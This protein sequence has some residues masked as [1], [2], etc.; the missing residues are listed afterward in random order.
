MRFLKVS[1]ILSVL[2]LTTSLT[3]TAGVDVAPWPMYQHDAFQSGSSSFPGPDGLSTELF[4][5]P[6]SAATSSP[7]IVYER[8][9]Y[10]GSSNGRIYEVP[11]DQDSPAVEIYYTGAGNIVSST[12]S[13]TADGILYVGSHAGLNY[14]QNGYLYAID[15]G[16]KS[17]IWKLRLGT[18][19]KSSPIVT[20]TGK[21]FVVASVSATEGALFCVDSSGTIEWQQSLGKVTDPLFPAFDTAS[22]AVDMAGNVYITS[23]DNQD[24][25]RL[26]VFRG[27]S[28]EPVA[29]KVFYDEMVTSSPVIG[30]D[31]ATVYIT[32][33]KIDFASIDISN[34][35]TL[36]F[37]KLRA[38]HVTGSGEFV[39]DWSCSPKFP[40]PPLLTFVVNIAGS[41]LGA[42]DLANNIPSAF[43][44]APAV[45]PDGDL[46]L[47]GAIGALY[48]ID[49]VNGEI[50]WSTPLID[51]N[52]TFLAIAADITGFMDELT[53]DPMA[54]L[55]RYLDPIM[56]SPIT[57]GDT[58][59][60]F[61]IYVRTGNT[62]FAYRNNGQEIGSEYEAED[63][64]PAQADK[65]DRLSG[66]ALGANR[67]VYISSTDGN[68]YGIGALDNSYKISGTITSATLVTDI[69]VSLT[70]S[71]VGSVIIDSGETYEFSNL[72]R[73]NYIVTP[74]K[75][76]VDFSPSSITI[77]AIPN[78]FDLVLGAIQLTADTIQDFTIGDANTP[79]VITAYLDPPFLLPGEPVSI[80]M[81]ITSPGSGTVDSVTFDLSALGGPP[82]QPVVAS[83]S[84]GE[85]GPAG[86]GY[87]I[88]YDVP[89]DTSPGLKEI[90]ITI[91]D[92]N[93]LVVQQVVTLDVI[94]EIHEVVTGTTTQYVTNDF[95]GQTLILTYSSEGGNLFLQVFEPSDD[96]DSPSYL[97]TTPYEFTMSS[98]E[99]VCFIYNAAAGIWKYVLSVPGSSRTEGSSPQASR[100]GNVET[101][102]AGTG[103]L[104]GKILAASDNTGIADVNLNTGPGGGARSETGG[105]YSF[106][107]SAG[108]FRMTAS[109]AGF[110]TASTS[111]DLFTG[112]VKNVDL[113]MQPGTFNPNPPS[114]CFLSSI[115]GLRSANVSMLRSYRDN[116]LKKSPSG[117]AHINKYYRYSP[118]I[119]EITEM[120]PGL[121]TEIKENVKEMMPL[122]LR[123]LFG[124]SV[125]MNDLQK[126]RAVN[127]LERIK[128]NAGPELAQELD[129]LIECIQNGELIGSLMQQPVI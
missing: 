64:A 117:N 22:P 1:L 109:K 44:S 79:P 11:L 111:V 9:I 19:V 100:T 119:V 4:K 60:Y 58:G 127:C 91:T 41:V 2:L 96:S 39:E 8:K 14:P 47:G 97:S 108:S 28:G 52:D 124:L 83:R 74:I 102:T 12:P 23:G 62:V 106:Q 17:L 26:S 68:I 76:G 37:S 53:D 104:F 27:T 67:V 80:V 25:Y 18:A 15:P 5:K 3:V 103:V 125:S 123:S 99:G 43:L 57:D 88:V 36:N 32:T 110:N 7:V 89:A 121:K 85:D 84:A 87:A 115:L 126:A 113:V 34:I 105:I 86:G 98:T 77:L 10:V 92:S 65:L 21:V 73:G 55:E 59:S 71:E 31:G 112:S 122:V 20:S 38:F 40:L 35:A 128:E 81:N 6:V 48:C 66:L 82:D 46:Y 49:P 54:A 16:S 75:D 61:R 120:D 42:E 101:S 72:M 78:I 29:E 24:G 118:E 13:V 69:E 50:K 107:T 129:E 56:T 114:T 33:L 45:G 90:I 51:V 30:A 70:G 94:N 116:V 95:D 93:G 63:N